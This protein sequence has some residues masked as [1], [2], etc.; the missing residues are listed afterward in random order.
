MG[1][2]EKLIKEFKATPIRCL[3]NMENFKVYGCKIDSFA[4]PDI[5]INPYGNVS[6]KGDFQELNLDCEYIIKGEEVKDKYGIVCHEQIL[7]GF[8]RDQ[9]ADFFDKAD[10]VL[11]TS[12]SE[13]S[14][15]V[16][17][18]AMS[19]NC[20]VISTNVGD[21][22]VVLNGAAGCAFVNEH[23]EN[24]LA[25][26]LFL[27]LQGQIPGKSPRQQIFDLELDDKAI[28]TKIYNVYKSLLVRK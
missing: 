3:C 19:C 28:T 9:L 24:A 1:N 4:Y 2:N 10:A 15:Q 27:S 23:E 21:V 13:G 18:E 22:E 12:I 7:H 14:P 6:I 26:K 16:V 5:K 8:T 25:E 17:K 20:P 11:M